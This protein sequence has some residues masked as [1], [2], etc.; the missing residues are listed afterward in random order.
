MEDAHVYIYNYCDV[1]DAGYFAIY[2]GHA[3]SQAAK[4]CSENLHDLIRQSILQ[5]EGLLHPSHPPH[6]EKEPVHGTTEKKRTWIPK[7]LSISSLASDSDKPSLLMKSPVAEANNKA[8][9][10]RASSR[11]FSVSSS[12]IASSPHAILPSTIPKEERIPLA[13]K[14]AFLNADKFMSDDVPAHTGTTAAVAVIRWER[15]EPLSEYDD[16]SIATNSSGDDK[17]TH[18]NTS[19]S[20]TAAS[21]PPADVS[22]IAAPASSDSDSESDS[23]SESKSIDPT[24][25]QGQQGQQDQQDQLVP[26]LITPENSNDNDTKDESTQADEGTDTLSELPSNGL[27]P[28]V[29]NGASS[30]DGSSSVGDA[31]STFSAPFSHVGSTMSSV[32]RKSFHHTVVRGNRKRVLYAANVGDSRIVLCRGGTALRLS[33]DHKGSDPH[34]TARIIKA[35]GL[36][37]GNRVN[38]M[39]AVTR[40]LGDGYMKSLVTGN[41]YTTRTELC[42]EDEFVIIACDG[43]WDVCTD[44]EAVELVRDVMD[45]KQAA[46]TLVSN[47]IRKYSSDNITCMVIRLDPTMLD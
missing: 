23:K 45:P 46:K 22:S 26:A 34:E 14:T 16:K 19:T 7:R 43:L 38:G 20:T 21:E 9:K 3:G 4:W 10:K 40:S 8:T 37:I 47:A 35:G 29:T 42:A 41:P 44:Q 31:D 17:S 18:T 27:H 28:V 1:P 30:I 15:I 24:P 39:L 12:A 2:D 33:Y 32:S 36:V 11:Q 5:N 6:S 25:A 13:F